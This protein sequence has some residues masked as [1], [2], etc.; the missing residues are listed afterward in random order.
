MTS[1]D[2]KPPADSHHNPRAVGRCGTSIVVQDGA[3]AAVPGEQRIAAEPEQVQVGE[4]G[5]IRYI[6]LQSALTPSLERLVTSSCG[7]KGRS[8]RTRSE[9]QLGH[10]SGR[11]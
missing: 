4:T 7:P 2:L 8:D 9:C 6:I 3:D 11:R 5:F 10:R 1:E